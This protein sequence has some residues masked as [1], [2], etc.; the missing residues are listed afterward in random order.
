[1]SLRSQRFRN[2]HPMTCSTAHF[3]RFVPYIQIMPSTQTFKPTHKGVSWE[4]KG[5]DGLAERV[6]VGVYGVGG[7]DD[8]VVDEGWVGF[9]GLAD[10]GD[11]FGEDEERHAAADVFEA[12]GWSDAQTAARRAQREVKHHALG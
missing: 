1:M 2:E 4:L 8:A 3:D 5:K 9:E 12:R 7:F 11:V 10:G 6:S